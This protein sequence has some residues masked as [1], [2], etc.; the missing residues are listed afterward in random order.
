MTTRPDEHWRIGGDVRPGPDVTRHHRSG[1]TLIELLVVI[2]I[3][4]VLASLLLPA[5]SAARRKADTADCLNNL[6]QI[7]IAIRLYAEDHEARLPRVPSDPM[8]AHVNRGPE[9]RSIVI[10]I[11]PNLSGNVEVFE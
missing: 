11:R 1:F 5:F 9:D 2:A 6:R 8:P 7:G 3:I 10:V 4:A